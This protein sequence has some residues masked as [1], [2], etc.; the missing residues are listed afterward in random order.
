MRNKG[1]ALITVISLMAIV[2]LIVT[3]GIVTTNVSQLTTLS[4]VRFQLAQEAADACLRRALDEV[5]ATGICGNRTLNNQDLG[6]NLNPGVQCSAQLIQSGRICFIRA[7]GQNS[8]ARVYKTAILQAFYGMGLYTV[9]GGVN[10]TYSGGLLT[11]CYYEPN[12]NCFVPAFIASS[13]TVSL[14]GANPQNCPA[15]NTNPTSGVWG[16]PPIFT[17]AQFTDLT[18][19]FFNV[20]CFASNFYREGERCNYGLT[21]AIVDTYALTYRDGRPDFAFSPH[22]EPVINPTLL[23]DLNNIA[24]VQ[25]QGPP[26]CRVRLD[27]II[28]INLANILNN[29]L[30][31]TLLGGLLG[32]CQRLEIY[33]NNNLTLTGGPSPIPVFVYSGA[34]ITLSG[35]NG[36]TRG[37]TNFGENLYNLNIYTLGTTTITANST[38][39]RLLTTNAVN[40]NSGLTVSNAT[41]IQ[42][43]QNATQNNNSAS[44]QNFIVG[45]GTGT[46]TLTDSKLITRQIRFGTLNAWRDLVYVYANA[47][48]NCGRDSNTASIDACQNDNRRCGW[49]SSQGSAYFGTDANRNIQDASGRPLV[50]LLINNNSVV[51][52]YN[53]FFGGIYFGQ[54]VNY[55]QGVG[56]VVRGFLVRN[57]PR[58]LSLNIGFNQNTD[59]RFRL[60]AI[61]N[62]RYD[63]NRQ[64]FPG[65]WFVRRVDCVRELPTPGYMSIITRMTSW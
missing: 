33:T 1:F 9:R 3:A 63:P 57:F 64:G 8:N 10:A 11:G 19:L 40:V 54:D 20:N 58:N 60:D 23:S 32:Q 65:F 43:L 41:I 45:G 25:N 29:T 31:N 14:G 30:L 44:P 26:N 21:D 52:A 36:G 6:L 35:V 61:N 12:N 59:F 62:L 13:G 46:L 51:R 16:L 7:V 2:S 38:N 18:P 53:N 15:N 4:T 17:N 37:T 50:S 34:N 27:N 55:I 22:G 39:F 24:N 42:A 5:N 56:A 48:P 49:F 28:T 47:C